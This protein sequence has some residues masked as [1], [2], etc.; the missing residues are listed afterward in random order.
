MHTWSCCVLLKEWWQVAVV[1]KHEYEIILC[2]T[3]NLFPAETCLTLQD[4]DSKIIYDIK[5]LPGNKAASVLK[6]LSFIN[7]VVEFDLP[8]LRPLPVFIAMGVAASLHSWGVV[9][10]RGKQELQ[11]VAAGLS[12]C[13]AERR[14]CGETVCPAFVF[15]D[16]VRHTTQLMP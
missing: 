10:R 1:L 6:G 2:L 5:T 16:E 9:E 3:Y 13:V 11:K 15:V 14:A 12:K 4:W 8:Q 7:T